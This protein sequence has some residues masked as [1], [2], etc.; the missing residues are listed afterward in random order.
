MSSRAVGWSG[1]YFLSAEKRKIFY[2]KFA[3]I[4]KKTK[5]IFFSQSYKETCDCKNIFD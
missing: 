1:Q 4:V 3:A 2:R 5:L